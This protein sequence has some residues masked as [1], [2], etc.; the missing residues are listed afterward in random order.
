MK[1]KWKIIL[2]AILSVCLIAVLALQY[3]KPLEAEL[4]TLQRQDLAKTF[5]EEGRVKAQNETQVY[6]QYGGKVLK[7][8]V[9][10]GDIVKAGDLLT[11]FDHQALNYQIQ[12]L[13]AQLRSIE[14]QK[15]LQVLTIDLEA[16]KLLYEAGA[17][18]QKEFEEAKNTIDSDYY[19]ALLSAVRSQINQL[20][21]QVNLHNVVSPISGT[22]AEIQVKEGMVVPPA[23]PLLTVFNGD[24]VE[25]ETFVLT[26]DASRIYAKMPVDLIQDNRTGDI[27]FPGTVERIAPSA[28]EK[29][30]T[31]GL[32]E[33]RLSVTISPQI[34]KDLLLKPGYALDVAFTL[35]KQEDQLAVPKTVLFPYQDG[36][37]VWVVIE[38]KAEIRPIKKGFETDKYVA[39]S[40]GLSE[41]DYIILNPKLAGLKEGK[42]IRDVNS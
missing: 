16:K 40:E 20:Y 11:T 13:Q 27:V 33:Q 42:T 12:N 25:V 41:G 30:S 31:L 21:Y 14:A 5:K 29:I 24:F 38:D 35:D 3:T 7:V 26:E 8:P 1:K 6:T 2:G 19:P 32:V 28:V 37:A 18:S 17:I 39:I 10:E 22:V 9:K 23:S 36:D 4:L 34:P 15:D